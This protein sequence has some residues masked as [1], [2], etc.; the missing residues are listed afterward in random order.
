[1][2]PIIR[3]YGLVLSCIAIGGNLAGYI[4]TLLSGKYLF[5]VDAIFRF[6]VYGIGLS[7]G[8]YGYMTFTQENDDVETTTKD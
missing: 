3:K 8:L 2:K 4:D 1:M 7:V 6:F 5:D